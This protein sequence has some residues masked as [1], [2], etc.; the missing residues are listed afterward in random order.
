MK[1]HHEDIITIALKAGES[2]Y[3]HARGNPAMLIAGVVVT[4]GVAIGYGSYVYGEKLINSIRTAA[5]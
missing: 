4:A 2:V 5:D 1:A 3:V